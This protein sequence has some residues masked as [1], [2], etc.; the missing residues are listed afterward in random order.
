MAAGTL[1]ALQIIQGLAAVAS[2]AA[3]VSSAA[4]PPTSKLSST[5]APAGGQP[6]QAQD[7]FQANH[8]A[9]L[10]TQKQLPAVQAPEQS[11]ALGQILANLSAGS[12]LTVTSLPSDEEL[13][14]KVGK[15]NL[16][17]EAPRY[18][19]W[20][21][22]LSG[23]GDAAGALAALGPLLFPPTSRDA[24]I[25]PVAGGGGGGGPS[26]FQLPQRNTLAQILASLPRT[27]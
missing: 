16:N 2:A 12:P 1:S 3:A 22:K 20:A 10:G 15:I 13:T 5:G 23:V 4:N 14:P 21:D 11:M 27:M 18:E 8:S 25:G 7:I 6:K 17:P 9:R 19:N 26:V 24:M